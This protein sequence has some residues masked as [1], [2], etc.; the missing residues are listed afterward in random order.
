MSD[1]RYTLDYERTYHD[2]GLIRPGTELELEEAPD[3]HWVELG[4]DGNPVP[5]ADS[6]EA[7]DD[8]LADMNAG[9]LVDWVGEHPDHAGRVHALEVAR[10]KPRK[11]VLAA[12]EP[13]NDEPAAAGDTTA[14]EE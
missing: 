9:E 8:D 7:T 10:P 1:F 14:S 13:H 12:T 3:Q 5:R 11:T 2:L 6:A 4:P